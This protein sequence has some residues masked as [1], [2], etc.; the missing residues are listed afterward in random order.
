[1]VTSFKA[2]SGTDVADNWSE[3]V[4]ALA[5]S[6]NA[7]LASSTAYTIRYIYRGGI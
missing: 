3:T 5:I 1:M 2:A 4:G 7:N 6:S